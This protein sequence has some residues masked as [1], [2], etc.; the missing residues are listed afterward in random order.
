MATGVRFIPEP[1]YRLKLR[2]AKLHLD[3]I[4]REAR[5]FVEANLDPA[6]GFEPKPEDEW[7][8]IRRGYVQPLSPLWGTYLGDFLHNT[9]SALDNLVCAMIRRNDPSH[10]LKRAFFPAYQS[11]KEWVSN[12]VERDRETEG[13]A[14]TDGVSREVLTAIK[15]SQPY[16]TRRGQSSMARTPL[17][18]LQAASN[19]DKHQ[20]LHATVPRIAAPRQ[21]T[22]DLKIPRARFNMVPPGYFQ[23]R[24]SRAAT[25]GTPIETGAEMGRM[26]LRTLQLPPPDADV[27]VQTRVAMEIAFGVEGNSVEITHWDIWA[28]LNETWRTT[29]RVEAAAG[30]HGLPPIDA[31][32]R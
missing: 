5:A 22:P 27:G 25:P 1:G 28:M 7:T 14:P 21:I 29:L 20:A 3:A 18:L 16:R 2:R 10:S 4:D 24:S 13:F 32:G 9:R 23:I 19:T 17:I 12:V 6:V 26:K 15:E 30:I 11:E 31:Y 8:I